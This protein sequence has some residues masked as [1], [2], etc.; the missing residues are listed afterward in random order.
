M[1]NRILTGDAFVWVVLLVPAVLLHSVLWDRLHLH[2]RSVGQ[3]AQ[4]LKQALPKRR[5]QLRSE[6]HTA[7]Q[8]DQINSIN[9]LT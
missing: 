6:Y 2:S 4:V 7:S 5:G 9:T 3:H 1:T 8:M